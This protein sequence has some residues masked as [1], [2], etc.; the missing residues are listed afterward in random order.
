M[1]RLSNSVKNGA[2]SSATSFVTETGS[3]SAAEPFSVAIEVIEP[4]WKNC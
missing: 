2:I 4:M 1:E 3:G